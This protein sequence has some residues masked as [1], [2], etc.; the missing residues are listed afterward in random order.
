MIAFRLSWSGVDLFF[1]LSGFLIGGILIDNRDA[2]NLWPVFYLRR[3]LRILP[4]YFFILILF[5]F[6]LQDFPW[7]LNNE[8]L[9][10]PL[11]L[12]SYATFTQNFLIGLKGTFGSNWL[13]PTWSLAIEEQ[14]YIF[15]PFLIVF[16]KPKLLPW[17]V[18]G[19][20]VIATPL[21]IIFYHAEST[22]LSFYV[23]MPCR[24]DSLLMGV[25]CAIIYRSP[26]AM[27]FIKS[28]RSLANITMAI[29]FY[30]VIVLGFVSSHPFSR[31][32]VFG[33]YTL[34]AALYAT[35]LLVSID[36]TGAL[37]KLTT[38]TPLRKLGEI[39]FGVYLTHE[40]T[41]GLAFIVL[42]GKQP[43]IKTAADVFTMLA[44]L[45]ATIAFSKASWEF[46][47]RRLNSIGRS[48]PFE[49]STG[50]VVREEMA[51]STPRQ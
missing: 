28:N 5:A 13:G 46:F 21:R 47:E 38:W 33:G 6:F 25:A 29:L 31:G 40:I 37:K 9:N 48:T 26:D 44:A 45:V 3:S 32:M 39:A 10:S 12:W 49:Q 17:F 41:L 18:L 2:K 4:L 1:V 30:A 36:D 24:M 34:L 16:L 23:L 22:F 27:N 35:V 50:A 7:P 15:L 20:I 8:P 43:E 51:G 11:P 42:R 14:F 19:A